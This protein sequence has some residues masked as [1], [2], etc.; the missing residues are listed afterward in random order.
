M[1]QCGS[2]T[3][4]EGDTHRRPVCAYA[5]AMVYV[6][7]S[8][9]NIEV[10][11]TQFACHPIRRSDGVCH[12]VECATQSSGNSK[13]CV[14]PNSFVTQSNGNVEVCVTQFAGQLRQLKNYQVTAG[15][16]RD[17]YGN[18]THTRR[19]VCACTEAMVY[20]TQSTGN[21]EVCHPIRVTQSNGNKEV[22]VTQFGAEAMVY[23][24]ES[25]GNKEV[26][27]T[28]LCSVAKNLAR[29]V[30]MFTQP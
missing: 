4:W 30:S 14:S 24:T 25:T 7:E 13:V 22:C 18:V 2:Q 26:C 3:R 19:P 16:D 27:V 1:S 5:E 12:P 20:V 28:Q 8:T 29:H 17:H 6:T 11:V 23:V 15:P 9:G 10:C 21:K